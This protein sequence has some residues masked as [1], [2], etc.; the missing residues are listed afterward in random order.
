LTRILAPDARRPLARG[1]EPTFSVL[2]PAY[3]AARVVGDAVSSALGQTLAPLEVIVCDDGSTDDLEAA[4]APYRDRI[5]LL[6]KENG[7]GAS[8]LN[9]AAHAATGDFV[10]VLDSDDAYLPGRLEALA[11]LAVGR[12]DLDV[13]TTDAYFESAGAIVGRFNGPENPFPADGQRHAILER[14]FLL[15]PAVRR[16]RVLALGG[17]DESLRIAYDWDCWMR[18]ILDGALA[19][20][21]AEPLL[22]YRVHEGSLS[23]RRAESLRERVVV[24]EKNAAHPSLDPSELRLLADALARHGRLA[25]LAEAQQALERGERNA[26]RLAVEIARDREFGRRT[27]S[28]AVVLAL[29]PGP[30]RRRLLPVLGFGSRASRRESETRSAG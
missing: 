8:A 2:I 13:L 23:A 1:A 14:C 10:V 27:R 30:L 5:A 15:A 18:L 7:G 17:W 19:G 4:L 3:Q 28:R 21:V 12:P 25:L 26:W 24:L 11:E 6:R 20:S 16:T 22:R 9:E 29:T